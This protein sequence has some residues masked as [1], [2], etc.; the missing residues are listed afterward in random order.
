LADAERDGDR[1][2]AVVKGIGTSSD[3]RGAAI[4]EPSAAGQQKALGRAY[5]QAE[6]DPSTIELIEAHGTG[7]KVGD[8]VEVSAL[9]EVF[10]P[11]DKPWCAIGSI[12]S[13]IGHTKAAA[14]AAGVIKASLALY[15]KTLPPT[16]KV[17][18]PQ[19]A[20]TASGSAFYVNSEA[21]PWL[22]SPDHPR[23][24]G[25]SA[26]GFGGS[27]FHCLLEEH[28]PQ[29]MVADWTGKEQIVAFSA[30]QID[31]LETALKEFPA[32]GPWEE[33][34]LAADHSRREFDGQKRCRLVMVVNRHN[35]NPEK[36]CQAA[37]SLLRSRQ[38]QASW[39]TPDGIYFGQTSETGELAVLFPGQGAQYPGMLRDLAIQF[40]EFLDSFA[41]ADRAFADNA[42]AA[43][44]RLVDLVYPR[45]V[46][47]DQS[48]KLNEAQL[49]A[50][51][52]A[53]PALGAVSLAALAV[54]ESFGLQAKAF[55]GHSY[56]ELAALCAAGCY[57][58]NTLHVLSRLRGELM[59]AGDG[60]RGSMLAVA[61]PLAQIEAFLEE[62]GLELTLANRNTP[63]QGVL[64]G[65]SSV[66]D[67]AV[68]LLDEKGIRQTRLEVAAAFHSHLVAEAATPFA[69][70]LQEIDFQPLRQ[71]VYANTSGERYPQEVAEIRALLAGQL[72][73]PVDFVNEIEAMY[74]AGIRTFLEVGPGARLT[75]MVK[76]I[77]GE[78]PHQAI[79]LDASAGK[80]SGIE[81]LGRA[82]AQLA[83]AG[84]PVDLIR[85]DAEYATAQQQQVAKKPGLVVKLS[86]AN[87]FN[88]PPKRPPLPQAAALPATA[89]GP[90]EA[91][92]TPSGPTT[93]V[94]PAPSQ[95]MSRNLNDALQVTRQ[96]LAALQSLQEQTARL[97]QQFLAG[98]E[99][100][101]RTFMG[102]VEQ[103]N[104]LFRGEKLDPSAVQSTE[105]PTRPAQ[106]PVAAPAPSVA[107]TKPTESIFAEQVVA[108]RQPSSGQ[109]SGQV[110]ATLLAVVAEKTGYPVEMLEMEMSLDTD[111]GIDSIK[112]VEILSA[113]QEKLPDA[114]PVKPEDL[115]VL[116]TIGQIIEHL[117][118]AA[119]S[120]HPVE[121]SGLDH[122]Q[123]SETLLAVIAEK[124]GYPVEMLELG[125]ALD[126]D[127]G[128]DSI[129]RVEI[130]S[131]LQ[132]QLPGAPPIKP[133]HL[134]TLQTVGQIVD[135]LASVSGAPQPVTATADD[136]EPPVVGQGVERQVLQSMPLATDEQRM[137]LNL[138]RGAVVWVTD[139]GT[140][141]AE[142]LCQKLGDYDLRAEQ[143]AAEQWQTLTPPTNLAGLLLVSPSAGANDTFIENA[144]LL[145]QKA[146]PVL[147]DNGAKGGAL[148]ATISRLNGHFGL[149][150]GGPLEDPLSGG[151]AGL[152]KTA[153]HEWPEVSCRAFDLETDLD[154]DAAAQAL[155]AE[156]LTDGPQEVGLTGEGLQ[157]LEL[158][159]QPLTTADASS[160][161]GYGDVVVI[162]GGARGVTAEVAVALAAAS[163]ATLVLLG[164]SPLPATDPDWAEGLTTEAE[165]KKGILARAGS[166][167]KPLEVHQQCQTLLANRE[168]RRTL[169]R[170]KEAG[171]QPLYRSVDLRDRQSLAAVL[172]EIREEYG[173]FR[174]LIHGAGVLADRLIK[175][176]TSEQFH[177]V[178][179][180]KVDGLRNLLAAV[181]NDD[182]RFLVTFSSSTGR[183]G[184]AG[185]VDYAAAN[186]VLNKLAQ[187]QAVLRPDCRAL[188][189][190]WGPWDGGMVTPALKKVF[191]EEGVA[192]IDLKA[193]ADYLVK[194]ISG[195]P[196]GPVELVI[197]GGHDRVS[198]DSHAQPHENIYVSKA[199]DLEL[200]IDQYPFLKSH[201]IDGKAVLPMAVMI[202][203]MAHGAIHNNPGL[204]F[205]G[206]NDLRVMKGVTLSSGQSHSLQVMT[207]KAFKSDGLHVVPVE[208][209]GETSAGQKFIHARARIVLAARLPDGK[210]SMQRPELETY[211]RTPEQAYQ[212]DRLFHGPD[213]QG[214]R[215]IIGCAKSG[216]AS[217]V[218]PAPLPTEWI[219]QPLRNSWLADPLA[220]DV[221][222]QLMIL[223]SFEQYQAGS[224][225]V[226]AGRY[227]QY[228]D[229]FPESGVEIRVR[230][231]AQS[232]S[233]AT[234]EIDFVDPLSDSL[235]ARLENYECVIDAS[236]NASFQRNKLQGA[237]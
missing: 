214:I 114:P 48:R 225:P 110:A 1:V 141:L 168:I 44:E 109:E 140:V 11:A 103:Q 207:G 119:L 142:K 9:K 231:T 203:W 8:A 97:H 234:A 193:G 233:K 127:L 204:R 188:S 180:T 30:D 196:G 75:G 132:Q 178:Y 77:L 64:S 47:D 223:W 166:S 58:T 212:T 158:I 190:N 182:L 67:Q 226:F 25:V 221:S 169:Q 49:R 52:V 32:S 163:R 128:I 83:A 111:L 12:K 149:P 6:I 99:A 65:A 201:V 219:R 26:L 31:Q 137:P 147:T 126:S 74:A 235:V 4:Y 130:L 96:S 161:V 14:G 118:Q 143:V 121:A 76:A 102:L 107:P 68:R 82:L 183:F 220:L 13:Q 202:E 56:G 179:A 59:A 34:R 135:F 164:R 66:I 41:N 53:Q 228:R 104:R 186:E 70:R 37:L 38:D 45:P 206:L 5:R 57:A 15:H 28:R 3:G 205:H 211:Q 232:A 192:I 40:P 112:R 23:R 60:D 106:S 144:F 153:S 174:G 27:N 54:L 200:S 209:S 105:A 43:A 171:G 165:L 160:P 217:L 148:L 175:D 2:Y 100:T 89:P 157:T 79:A 36:Q 187:Q 151:L 87:Y 134:G 229:R 136:F 35:S 218:R 93:A 98:Q 146:A 129:K 39:S 72:A 29:K 173:P 113:L 197:L 7:T 69:Q 156:L 167:L 33:L 51:Q 152:A 195:P 131:A 10:G 84:H 101:T 90:P 177:Q 213:F 88:P 18:K 120:V 62:S 108:A 133:E 215:E 117:G 91:M 176:K 138:P 19:Q 94:E 80:R 115:G 185:Q 63:E 162:S 46:F 20:V 71:A 139:D 208:L 55:A 236:L 227:R 210:P 184:R 81:D 16:I 181:G 85:W 198:A 224:L 170:I 50:T 124:T 189:L 172:G 222:F 86:G 122:G 154:P 155:V 95:S 230:V 216:I 116:Q 78:R 159:E 237:A 42:S 125:M 199:F 22:P 92:E 145:M 73:R 150:A 194:E 17:A 123:V 21:R 191:A 24:A 61:A